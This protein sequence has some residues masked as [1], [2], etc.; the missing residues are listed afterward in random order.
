MRLWLTQDADC[1]AQIAH[2]KNLAIA[3]VVLKQTD[4][5]FMENVLL[6]FVVRRKGSFIVENA[7]RFL[8]IC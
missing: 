5:L 6:R 7:R 2:S 4:T 3:V 8:V 1:T